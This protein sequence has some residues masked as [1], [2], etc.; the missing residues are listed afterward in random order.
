M[1]VEQKT[2]A[3]TIT[4]V[5]KAVITTLKKKKTNVTTSEKSI[6]TKMANCKQGAEAYS[7]I[8]VSVNR[9]SKQK[10]QAQ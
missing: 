9:V 8:C 10:W 4:E 5:T 7:S 6:K 3:V 2:V 1:P